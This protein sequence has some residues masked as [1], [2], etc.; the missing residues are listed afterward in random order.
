MKIL[1]AN[2]TDLNEI[3]ELQYLAYQSEAILLRNKN[4]PPLKQNLKDLQEEY[5]KKIFLKAIDENKKIIGS[6]RFFLED[7]AVYIGKLI[8]NPSNQRQGIG[9]KLLLEVEKIFP[10]KR[11][12]LFT[13]SKSLKNI[14]FYEKLGYKIFSEKT[15]S[16]D[17]TFVYLE[18][19]SI[20]KMRLNNES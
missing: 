19:K 17:L 20:V 5:K 12:E 8:V 2:E 13:S 6:V 18:K 9:T 1:R 10:D 3:L 11:Y 4:I 7:D 16:E 14:L 15:L